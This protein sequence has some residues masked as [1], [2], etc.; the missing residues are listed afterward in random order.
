MVAK[1]F[2][3]STSD[4]HFQFILTLQTFVIFH[5]LTV[6]ILMDVKWYL[7]VVLT[8]IFKMINI[9]SLFMCLL[10]TYITLFRAMCV[11]ILCVRP[12]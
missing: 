12:R 3:I 4:L 11:P 8:C 2:Y 5:F 9:D 10:T 6:A 7:I 1:P